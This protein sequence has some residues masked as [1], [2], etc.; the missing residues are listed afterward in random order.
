MYKNELKTQTLVFTPYHTL[1]GLRKQKNKLRKRETI[2]TQ[3][4]TKRKTH[5]KRRLIQ[6]AFH[7][8]S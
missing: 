1:L 4:L 8:K 7:R 2:L 5:E 3:K 6:L